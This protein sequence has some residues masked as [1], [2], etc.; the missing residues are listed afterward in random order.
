VAEVMVDLVS[1]IIYRDLQFI[2]E[3]EEAEE[4]E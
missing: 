3:A 1:Q 2:T 4:A